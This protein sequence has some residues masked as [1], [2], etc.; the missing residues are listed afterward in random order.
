MSRRPA[1]PRPRK[2]PPPPPRRRPAPPPRR[3][4]PRPQARV[5]DDLAVT[6]KRPAP[7][8]SVVRPP[9]RR[10]TQPQAPQRA[11]RPQHE[12][13]I[14]NT[15]LSPNPVALMR[16]QRAAEARQRKNAAGR[17][18][19]MAQMTEFHPG[20]ILAHRY[21]VTSVLGRGRGLLLDAS[22][23]SFDQRVVARIISPAL[24]DA[25]AVDRFQ[26]ETRI[27][28][29]LETEYVARIID[30]GTLDNGALY[31]VREYL[32]GVSLAE[33]AR[34]SK[35][36][37]TTTIDLF[38]QLCEA[39]QEAHSR[40]VVLRD[41]QAAHVFVTRKR[42]GQ[43]IAKV[44]DFG[45]CK[46]MK[47]GDT[48]EQS[49][50]KLLGLSSSASPELVRQMKDI[51]ERA[52]VWSLGC[53]LYELLSGSP[54]FQGDGAMLM[55]SIANEKPVPPSSL[56]RDI[57]V[58]K[59][60]DDAIL[61]ALSK[62]RGKRFQTVYQ[63]AAALKP[64]AST[65]GQL[66]IQQ[67]AKLAG[68]ENTATGVQPY[69]AAPSDTQSFARNTMQ[70][71][72]HAGA[73]F[74]IAHPGQKAPSRPSILPPAPQPA[75]AAYVPVAQATP[76]ASVPT[77]ASSAP[78]SAPSQPAAQYGTYASV[79]ATHASYPPV[80]AD[81]FLADQS[82]E[83][84]S[85]IMQQPRRFGRSAAIAGAFAMT[86]IA[87]VLFVFALTQ[88]APA[89]EVAQAGWNIPAKSEVLAQVDEQPVEAD[90]AT[91]D[92]EGDEDDDTDDAD[93][94]EPIVAESA[95][96]RAPAPAAGEAPSPSSSQFLDSIGTTKKKTKK[97]KKT[98]KKKKRK[99]GESSDEAKPAAKGTIV[100]MAIGASC[101]FAIDGAGR[102]QSSQVRAKVAPG[103]HTVSCQPVGGPARTKSVKVAPGKAATAVF[104]F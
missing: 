45:T 68:E 12:L 73:P 70:Q 66:L 89:A 15:E 101:S 87:I 25:K 43:P 54:A 82:S 38:L 30:V 22:H 83:L 19:S 21:K 85:L 2:T 92:A 23:V 75:Q 33:H 103:I 99:K 62:S 56:R 104:K 42:N 93:A 74:P 6:S 20:D 95:A 17:G 58:P 50:T 100:A 18:R 5:S 39:V 3:T 8:R 65:R 76:L 88:T 49:C 55:L 53:I 35:L 94:D 63:L 71:Q 40:G 36:D 84:D 24:A 26:R 97:S 34:S 37:L 102:G 1:P 57:D 47:Q 13:E 27:L 41:L 72:V 44:T 86:P 7:P 79:P 11:R 78:A 98:K 90:A 46:V 77:A 9:Q 14:T 28:S 96:A 80:V 61:Q 67:I 69:P 29:Q 64:Y 32:E 81:T 60:I 59:A 31:L 91:D 4:A 51:D 48:D 16:K 52:D 10:S